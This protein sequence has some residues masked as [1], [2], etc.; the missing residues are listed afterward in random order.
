MKTRSLNNAIGLGSVCALVM[1]VGASDMN[2]YASTPTLATVPIENV[3]VPTG[4]DANDN[5]EVIVHG[6]LPNLCHKSPQTKI[7]VKGNRIDIKVEALNYESDNP[8]CAPLVVPFVQAISLGVLDKGNYNIH[9]NNNTVYQRE[10]GIQIAESNS[11]AV[12]EHIYA[13]VEYVDRTDDRKVVLKGYNPS[14]CLELEEIQVISNNKDTYSIL[15]KMRQT[16]SF[17]PMKMV[18]FEYEMEVPNTIQRD[19]VLLHVRAMQGKAVN[20]LYFNKAQ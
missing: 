1:A 15:P 2:A 9:V 18:P 17:C 13:A 8:F 10:A 19:K 12:D 5:A 11:D 6:F 7:E 4:F 20:S 14:D 3:Y 16:S